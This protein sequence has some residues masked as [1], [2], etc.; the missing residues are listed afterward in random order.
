MT[1]AQPLEERKHPP[2]CPVSAV[3]ASKRKSICV[4]KEGGDKHLSSSSYM[5]DTALF[6]LPNVF[7][8]SLK[9]SHYPMKEPLQHCREMSQSN[10]NSKGFNSGLSD[11]LSRD[12]SF[13]Q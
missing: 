7:I 12:L 13:V 11:A 5:L 4:N 1:N 10:V 6:Y 8:F 9:P 3:T 2:L